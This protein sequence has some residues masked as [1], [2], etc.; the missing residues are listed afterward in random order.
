MTEK[1]YWG[2]AFALAGGVI[3][4]GV[5]FYRP[6]LTLLHVLVCG[7][8]ILVVLLQ[9]GR[10]ADL[11]GAFG[12]AGGPAPLRPPRAPPPPPPSW[13][14]SSCCPRCPWPSS[15]RPPRAG[16]WSKSRS[17]PSSTRPLPPRPINLLRLRKSSPPARAPACLHR[18]RDWLESF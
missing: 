2:A 7:I 1:V 12:G 18:T 10:A 9:S 14:L 11:A 6:L 15:L 13:P 4:A 5:T 8:L 16:R 17:P 3:Y